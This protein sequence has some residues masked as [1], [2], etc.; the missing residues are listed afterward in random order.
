M[1]GRVFFVRAAVRH[2]STGGD[3]DVAVIGGGPGGYVAAIKAAQLGL[4]TICIEKRGALGGTCLNVGCIPSKALLNSSQMYFDATSHFKNYGINVGNVTLDIKTMMSQKESAVD[5]LTK[6]IEGLFKKNKVEYAKGYG[7]FVDATTIEVEGLDGK[8]TNIKAKNTIIAT[9]SEPVELPFMPFNDFTDRTCVSSTGALLLDKVPKTLAVI[10]GGVIGLELGSVWA[11]LGANVTVIEFMDKLCPTM[12]KE[13]ITAFQRSLK[14]NLNFKFKMSTKV[15]AADIRKDGVTITMEP[16][17]GGTPEK[18]EADVALVSVGRRPRTEDLGLDKVGVTLDNKKRI[19]VDDHF[20]TKVGNIY[21]IGDCIRGPMLAH[22]AEEEG[23]HV[24]EAISGKHGTIN[25]D[26]IPSVIYTH[27]E[28]A[29]VG[30]TEEELQEAKIEYSKGVFPFLANSR[31]RAVAS[32]EG[33]VKILADKKTDR[34]L[35]V[36]IM[37][38]AAG[39]QIHEAGLAIEYG[40]SCEDIARTCHAHPTLS[41]AI[42][43]AAMACYDKPIHS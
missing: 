17:A 9:G 4:K 6:G 22:K 15:T 34:I 16:A 33:M 24:A 3:F 39:E 1:R 41:E 30:K 7:R 20:K 28:V 10:G 2:F 21:A 43:E 25:Y 26:A 23:V 38:N 5:G 36:H 37:S 12:D 29:S 40:A 18:F 32:A 11:R 8:K 35:G 19:E 31:A 13:L 27:P 42:K 14:K